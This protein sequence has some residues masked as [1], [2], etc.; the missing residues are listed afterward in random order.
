M[1]LKPII[2]GIYKSTRGWI[3]QIT[4][5]THSSI[6]CVYLE[7]KDSVGYAWTFSDWMWKDSDW[8]KGELLPSH[9]LAG[10]VCEDCQKFCKQACQVKPKPALSSTQKLIVEEFRKL[11]AEQTMSNPRI[12]VSFKD[13]KF[14]VDVESL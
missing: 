5:I 6:S 7:H 9:P 13:G 14:Y 4:N 2:G 10:V 8:T 1:G 12:N 3:I 11:V